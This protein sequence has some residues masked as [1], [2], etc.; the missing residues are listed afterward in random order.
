MDLPL[1]NSYTSANY[2]AV[3]L[4]LTIITGVRAEDD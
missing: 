2:S 4:M 1:T 3:V